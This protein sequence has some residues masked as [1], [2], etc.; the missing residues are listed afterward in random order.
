LESLKEITNKTVE[1]LSSQIEKFKEREAELKRAYDQSEQTLKKRAGELSTINEKL[2]YEIVE[3]KKV[4]EELT[5]TLSL[6][7]ATLESTTD[8]M[9]VVDKTGEVTIYNQ[10][11]VEMWDIPKSILA[12]GN[13]DQ[14]AEF[15]SGQLQ[16]PSVFLNKV[17]ELY[18]H[19]D[20]VSFDILILKGGRVF[21]RHSQPQKIGQSIVGRAWS[22]RDITEQKKA[23]EALRNTE[24][25]LL[26]AHKMEA[27]GR[28]AT[29]VGHEINNPLA[30]INEKAGLM[31]DLLDLSDD[32]WKY[33][34][35]FSDLI[36]D[37]LQSVDRCRKI[38]HRLLGFK[39]RTDVI[40]RAMNLNSAV[41]DVL[42]F[43]E[44]EI[45]DKD[46][47]LEMNL[48][49]SLPEIVSDIGQLQQVLLNIINNAVEAIENKGRIT[50]STGTKDKHTLQVSVKDTGEGIS[51]EIIK[52]IFEPFFTTKSGK[53]GTGLGL[54][55]SYGIMQK[56][57]GNIL[58]DS[59]VNEGSTF[60]IEVPKE[61]LSLSESHP[62]RS[63]SST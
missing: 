23:E 50:V 10:K 20:A 34:E 52:H 47:R 16:N 17:K 59:E 7:T 11:F 45:T 38:T 4:E 1:H 26:H 13:H 12:S 55:I 21:E 44:K 58:V 63:E 43:M 31:N 54:S 6:L 25:M 35:T 36:K 18:N 37:I 2:W 8:G 61:P 5:E 53:K 15:T 40:Y 27:I 22:F 56:L 62:K 3:R 57:G 51:D 39:K 19:P 46:I 41:K 32:N 33:K 30:V 29:G 14:I 24:L 60:I 42:D 49:E 48:D 9:L 28:L